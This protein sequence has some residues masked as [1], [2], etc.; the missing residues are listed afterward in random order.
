[1]CARSLLFS[2]FSLLLESIPPLHLLCKTVRRA[3]LLAGTSTSRFAWAQ[4]HA[5]ECS[6]DRCM[7]CA[8]KLGDDA[9]KGKAQVAPLLSLIANVTLL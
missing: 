6:A 5:P 3:R 2:C 1:V 9:N 4:A 7:D 8:G